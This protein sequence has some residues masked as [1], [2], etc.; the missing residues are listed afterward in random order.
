MPPTLLLANPRGFPIW[1][2]SSVKILASLCQFY[3]INE[4][5]KSMT[6]N[7]LF[8]AFNTLIL[9]V[10]VH[11]CAP[12][13]AKPTKYPSK[14]D[15]ILDFETNFNESHLSEAEIGAP[16]A[17][18][19]AK[20]STLAASWRAGQDSS[21]N[22]VIRA[23]KDPKNGGGKE[24]NSNS[25]GGEDNRKPH[26][27]IQNILMPIKHNWCNPTV[28]PITAQT[29][30]RAYLFAF[31]VFVFL[32][33]WHLIQCKFMANY[34]WSSFN[35][36]K[37]WN[38]AAS[39]RSEIDTDPEFNTSQV[40]NDLRIVGYSESKVG[41]AAFR[42]LALIVILSHLIVY[43][44][45]ANELCLNVE[46]S[47]DMWDARARGYILNCALSIL[48]VALYYILSGNDGILF[49]QVAP[50]STCSYIL[51]GKV[52]E[53]Q[54]RSARTNFGYRHF[55]ESSRAAIFGFERSI[56]SL[57]MLLLKLFLCRSFWNCNYKI[58][59]INTESYEGKG[60][61]I[62]RFK[63]ECMHYFYSPS[64]DLFVDSSEPMKNYLDYTNLS[65]L[66][67]S[68]G[69]TDAEASER[70]NNIGLNE[71][72]VEM[73]NFGDLL[74]REVTD[75]I[76]LVQLFVTYKSL[77]WRNLI[78]A[79]IWVTM[80]SLSIVNKVLL[81]RKRQLEVQSLSG[82]S[83]NSQVDVLRNNMAKRISAKYLT[84]GDVVRVKHNWLVPCDMI[85]LRGN[86]SMDE[87]AL[88]GESVPV[89]KTQLPSITLHPA[90]RHGD[91]SR[92]PTGRIYPHEHVLK[93]GTRV[94]AIIGS[95]ESSF[96]TVAVVIATGAYTLK[97]K[98]IKG[99]L[100]PSQIQLKYDAQLPLVIFLTSIYALVCA[101]Y[102]V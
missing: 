67:K 78:T 4:L 43:Y 40:L 98:Q 45:I 60:S 58:I 2:F 27:Y 7:F 9:L 20:R 91:R 73:P 42:V 55:N 89:Q 81:I 72:D 13:T 31:G 36:H 95:D 32:L 17:H 8:I 21:S 50:L 5:S 82:K 71:I 63:H 26:S 30:W 37:V 83:S 65:D 57:L 25:N 93:A 69:L 75:Y 11:F 102:Q 76:F 61:T 70:I 94:V 46:A 86:V 59:K 49:L 66:M 29:T 53:C 22:R 100:F 68:G 44:L 87:S 51:V 10:L 88:T 39:T 92:G 90:I 80:V 99:M 38:L 84:V 28:I 52:S 1:A 3:Q 41:T 48:A 96:E 33:V 62:R 6:L 79:P 18:G 34:G 74:R 56:S 64:L 24:N 101:L 85:L 15:R 97:G 35:L 12:Y 16:F 14:N 54:K 47:V 77:Y 23:G 19:R